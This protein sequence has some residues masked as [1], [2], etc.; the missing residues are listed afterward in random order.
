MDYE[1]LY[2]FSKRVL[3]SHESISWVGIT[4]KYSVLL[5]T[6]Q[7]P[8]SNTFL[9]DEENEE[10]SSSSITRH[11]KITK[12]EPKIGKVKY[13]FG[14]YKNL[15]RATIPIN[16]DFYLLLMFDSASRYFDEVITAKIIP[17]IENEKLRF[18]A[19]S[20]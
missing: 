8:G 12:L 18:V 13:A 15:C 11:K 9:T 6:E 3:S 2:S 4:N 20:D 7:R 14:R 5:A 19:P 16:E 17:M 1:F 10:F